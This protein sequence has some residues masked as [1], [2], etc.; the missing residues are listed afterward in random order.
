MEN[1]EIDKTFTNKK[2]LLKIKMWS[3][4][5]PFIYLLIFLVLRFLVAEFEEYSDYIWPF[6]YIFAGFAG[7]ILA[8]MK[9]RSVIG[10]VI[11]CLIS[12]L[13]G[14]IIIATLSKK[15]EYD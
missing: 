4:I 12:L 7:G 15:E 2:R 14:L 6:Y 9:N 11:L 3:W 1:S 8:K 13:L 5:I 10:W